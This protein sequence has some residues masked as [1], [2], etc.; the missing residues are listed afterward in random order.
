MLPANDLVRINIAIL[1]PTICVMLKPSSP[2]SN[3]PSEGMADQQAARFQQ[4]LH[5]QEVFSQ[6]IQVFQGIEAKDKVYGR[7]LVS[8][9]RFFPPR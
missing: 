9:G 4:T 3:P 5:F 2:H 8:M 7:W 1:A 6:W